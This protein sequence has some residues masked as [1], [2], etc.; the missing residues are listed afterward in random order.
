IH[1]LQDGFELTFTEDLGDALPKPEEIVLTQ[2]D[3]DY[4]WEYGSPERNTTR[5][6]VATVE[7]GA[8][9]RTMILRVE[10]GGL[11]PGMMARCLLPKFASKAGTALLHEEFA[12]TVN[13]LPE[14]PLC[15]DH[16]AKIAP[17]P[18]LKDSD[19]TGWLRLCYGDAFDRW[20]STGWD[21]VDVELDPT[22]PTKM[23]TRKGVNALVNSVP[24]EAA[25]FRSKHEFG[26]GL[27]HVEFML[28]RDG[29][30]S[31]LLQDRYEM[32]L[33]AKEA[34]GVLDLSVCGA[35]QPGAD[36]AGKAP[37]SS[38]FAGVGNWQELDIEFEAPRF[39]ASGSK[40]ENARIVR[41]VLN[42]TEI[43]SGVQLTGPSKGG[44]EGERAL[45]PLT[46]RPHSSHAALGNIR[47]KPVYE[48]AKELDLEA[49]GWTWLFED[50]SIEDWSQSGEA[51]WT[52]EFDTI[53]G[54]GKTGHLFSPNV[55]PVEF[56]LHA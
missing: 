27:L 34:D 3:Y 9:A 22:D 10:E 1:L 30:V 19:E 56:E 29:S 28:P 16:I 50:D 21:L 43:L 5:V 41:A 35:L 38:A 7:R 15:T 18:P 23:I 2:Y 14:G 11:V 33:S 24:E 25:D 45:A 8:D 44:A 37:L 36:F 53:F 12:Y 51:Q 40:T 17:P 26:D 49:A 54:N 48:V 55:L 6:P 46:F 39:D 47:F 52:A 31:I 20:D 4:W 42:G 13:Q 32:L